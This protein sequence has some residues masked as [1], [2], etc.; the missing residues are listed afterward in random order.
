MNTRRKR[1]E[2]IMFN[3]FESKVFLYTVNTIIGV[4]RIWHEL[5]VAIM[6]RIR[7]MRSTHCNVLM[8][9][10]E[11]A[12]WEVAF[13]LACSETITEFLCILSFVFPRFLKNGAFTTKEKMHE[14]LGF[15]T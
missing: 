6:S 3:V 2:Y 1:S 4:S 11:R 8:I 12:V 9:V 13:L 7:D 10:I 5:F 15:V 14:H